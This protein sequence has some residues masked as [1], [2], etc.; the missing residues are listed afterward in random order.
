MVAHSMSDVPVAKAFD[1]EELAGL[2]AESSAG[3]SHAD[4]NDEQPG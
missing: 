3:P 4:R 1:V 2:P